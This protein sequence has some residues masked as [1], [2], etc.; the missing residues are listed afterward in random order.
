MQVQANGPASRVVSQPEIGGGGRGCPR[1]GDPVLQGE[2]PLFPAGGLLSASPPETA[3][4]H[5]SSGKGR[6]VRADWQ[7]FP[8]RLF[9]A[10]L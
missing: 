9:M 1:A 8:D 6:T 10:S 5:G 4:L 7:P 3:E 2:K